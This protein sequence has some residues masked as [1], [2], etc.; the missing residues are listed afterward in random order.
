MNPIID[1]A[2]LKHHRIDYGKRVDTESAK[3]PTKVGRAWAF[4][5]IAAIAV[6][7]A[8]SLNA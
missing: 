4:V 6:S 5:M 8:T 3:R 2:M 1:T 7:L